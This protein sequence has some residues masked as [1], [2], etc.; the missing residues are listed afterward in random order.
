MP[1]ERWFGNEILDH[2][3]QSVRLGRMQQG[4]AVLVGHDQDDHVGVVERVSIDD[5]RKGR[6]LVR[7][8]RGE[9]ANE[10]FND[11]LDGIRRHVS[12]GYQ[13]FNAVVEQRGKDGELDTV[14][15]TDWEP[16]EVSI[17]SVPADPS[18]GIGRSADSPPE[19]N[20]QNDDPQEAGFFM[21]KEKVRTMTEEIK[22]QESAPAAAKVDVQA[23]ESEATKNERARIDKIA[24]A[25]ERFGK[26]ELARKF[27]N[28]GQSV[29]AF[30]A[31]L[32]EEVQPAAATE[33]V[34]ELDMTEKE[35]REYS[36][37]RAV[38]AAV[39]G[40]WSKAGLERECSIAIADKTGREAR[41]FYVPFNVQ[42]RANNV[43]T[44]TAGG[45]LVATDH[46]AGSF[47]DNLRAQS[48]IGQ[49]G[50]TFLPGLVGNVDIPRKDGSASFYWL[51]EDADVTDSDLVL[52]NV[53]LSPKTVAGSTPMTRRLMKQSSPAIESLIM[54]DLVRGAALAIDAAAFAGSGTANQPRGIINQTGVN[55]QTI[56][57]VT[58]N[59]PTFAELV[60]FETKLAEDNALEGA[61]S[62]V[63]TPSICGSMKTTKKD[64]GSGIFLMENGQ[65]NGY[66]VNNTTNVP[67]GTTIFG[68]F[69]DVLIGMWGVLDVM[70]DEAAKAAS[71][72]LVLRVF[73]DV[74]VAIRHPESFCINA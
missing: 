34:A 29:D 18:V 71:G 44:D 57:D 25:G 72:G 7:F 62:Y 51:A 41:G 49:L 60:G 15:V 11:V 19:Q 40:D 5:D 33:S 55:T 59:Y 42:N 27:I 14:R 20:T 32:L 64:A 74:D 8:G 26:Q 68:N 3:A 17:V 45:H 69:N 13:I 30:R 43:G 39:T 66:A 2:S 61:L 54:S 65:A 6:V 63:T 46:L 53:T 52:G 9:R 58:N 48:I 67:A 22:T 4:A 50:A 37:M 70:P 21:S 47:I 28:E 36:I 1:V 24:S 56:A 35:V 12:V 38:Q 16:Y 23:I 10:I 73:Q 31:K